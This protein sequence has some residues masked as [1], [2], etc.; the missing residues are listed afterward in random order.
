MLKWRYALATSLIIV[1]AVSGCDRFF[2]QS[3]SNDP[4]YSEEQFN[5]M[6]NAAPLVMV[7]FGA[8]WCGPCRQIDEEL[9]SVSGNVK[10]VSI[11]VDNN[12]ELTAQFGIAGIP[13]LILFRDGQQVASQSGYSSAEELSQW[14]ARFDTDLE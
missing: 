2:P 7:K 8:P 1:A 6:V 4:T 9:P 14:A 13:T 5:Q 10:V 3:S 11:N 12:P